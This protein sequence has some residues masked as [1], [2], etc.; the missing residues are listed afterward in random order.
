MHGLNASGSSYEFR[1]VF[2]DLAED[3]HVVAPDLPG[4]GRSD[5]PPLLYSGPLYATFVEDF[6]RDVTEDATVV[7]SSLSGA[8]A[9]A[10]AKSVDFDELVLVCP[11]ATTFPGQR[12]WLRTAFRAPLLG[13]A[14][15]NLVT[16]KASIR[17]FNAD[18]GYY[19]ADN[20]TDDL[21]D[22]QWRTSH[23]P[24][25]RYAVGSFVGGYLDLDID[26]GN[27]LSKLDESVT[28]VWGRQARITPLEGGQKLAEAANARLLVFDEC[29]V[30]PH[31]EHP[32]QFVRQVLRE[33]LDPDATTIEI[34]DPGEE[35]AEPEE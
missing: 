16:S 33:Q 26:L 17:Y 6:A 31:V 4:F 12:A 3:Y 18:H 30:Q 11:T 22:Y 32:D 29:D 27:E 14:L 2:A 23:Q 20:I 35:S 34:E 28:L 8:Y 7:A 21:V 25:A 1:H 19:D 5:R 15:F 10:A 24:G 9:T 13:E